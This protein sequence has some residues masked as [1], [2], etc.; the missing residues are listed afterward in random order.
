[1]RTPKPVTLT[2]RYVTLV[3]LQLEHA[4]E[5]HRAALQDP[6][7]FTYMSRSPLREGPVEYVAQILEAQA[8][9]EFL[10]FAVVNNSDGEVVGST[11]YGDIAVEHRRLEI[12]WTWL[13][14]LLRG[15]R[16]NPEMK[17]LLLGHAFERLGCQRVALKSDSRNLRSLRAIENIGAVREGVL[18]RHIVLPDGHA[19]DTV[20][21]S[22]LAEEWPG[23]R[24]LLLER[25]DG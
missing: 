3:P 18:R 15:T 17:L 4:D 16:A 21:Y 25:V 10:A 23:V 19:R 12:G 8:M 7:T 22:I 14:P 13:A 20:Y 6:K 24:K 1:M 11:R 9:G 2:G 5:L